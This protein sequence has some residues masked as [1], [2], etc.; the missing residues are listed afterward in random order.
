MHNIT[1]RIDQYCIFHGYIHN[2]EYL[3]CDYCNEHKSFINLKYRYYN[4]GFSR[5]SYLACMECHSNLIGP[6]KLD[7]VNIMERAYESILEVINDKTDKK[8]G[9]DT[10]LDYY[11]AVRKSYR[12]I[13]S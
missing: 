12:A 5:H 8:Q 4:Y 10:T 9:N 6:F 7:Q 1:T 3:E 13:P 11:E 2:E